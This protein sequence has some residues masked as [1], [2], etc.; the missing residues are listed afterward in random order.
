VLLSGAGFT[1][2][3]NRSV[4]G[5]GWLPVAG[6]FDGDGAADFVVYHASSG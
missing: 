3:L 4:G 1:T 5:V 6:D 2:A